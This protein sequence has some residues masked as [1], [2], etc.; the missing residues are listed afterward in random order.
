MLRLFLTA[1]A[2]S[3]LLLTSAPASSAQQ[4]DPDEGAHWTR[5]EVVVQLRAV[6]KQGQPFE[7]LKPEDLRVTVE[8]QPQNLLYFLRRTAEPLH[9]VI[10]L[11]A[12][13]SQELVLPQIQP[14]AAE[15]VSALLREGRNDAAVVS[16][17]DE[18]KVLQGL[19]ADAT[20]V[21]RA[22]GSVRFIP[23]PGYTGG[24]ILISGRPPKKPD[25]ALRAAMTAIWDSL[26]S[27]CD[28]LFAQ[29]KEGPRA[30]LL[31]SD[32]VDTTSGSKRDKAVERLFREGGSGFRS[33]I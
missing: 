6:G 18:A 32:G 2:A 12:S 30:V 11:D 13:A 1:V 21:R 27:V 20:S 10:M 15:F 29:A 26:A 16:F 31:V 14:A 7:G 25:P 19:T 8:G 17:T 23:P 24:G 4:G 33:R 9:V 3:V 22:I 5:P 28:E